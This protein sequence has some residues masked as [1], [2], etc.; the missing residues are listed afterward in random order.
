MSRSPRVDDTSDRNKEPALCCPCCRRR[1][2]TWRVMALCKYRG[3]MWISG[4]GPWAS[5]SRCPSGLQRRAITVQ[6]YATRQA[7]GRAKALIDRMA[8]GG[9]CLG[10]AGHIVEPLIR[11]THSRSADD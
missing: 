6:L 2:R 10:P 1:H 5:V 11:Q 8:C 7:A 9:G 4:E 3:A